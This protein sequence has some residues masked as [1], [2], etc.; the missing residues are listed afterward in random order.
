MVRELVVALEIMHCHFDVLW[1]SSSVHSQ[2][3]PPS[4]KGNSQPLNIPRIFRHAH[5]FRNGSSGIFSTQALLPTVVFKD[6][7]QGSS[8]AFLSEWSCHPLNSRVT[9][10]VPLSVRLRPTSASEFGRYFSLKD[11]ENKHSVFPLSCNQPWGQGQMW[12]DDLEA[13]PRKKS[14]KTQS[15][16]LLIRTSPIKRTKEG[17]KLES[18]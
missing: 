9:S 17:W 6:T 3:T 4:W 12:E 10:S 14:L 1:L 2:T 5:V 8:I 11:S 18:L 13:M 15:G 7:N 16:R